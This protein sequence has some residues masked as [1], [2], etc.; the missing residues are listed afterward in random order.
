MKKIMQLT[1]FLITFLLFGLTLVAPTG[2]LMAI[3]EDT[4]TD[5]PTFETLPQKPL[6]A[7]NETQVGREPVVEPE[8]PVVATSTQ[9]QAAPNP[10]PT[11]TRRAALAQ[12]NTT[13]TPEPASPQPAGT[14]LGVSTTEETANQTSNTEIQTASQATP[15]AGL[16]KI[17]S[18]ALVCTGLVTAILL[19]MRFRTNI[20]R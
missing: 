1:L 17:L 2:S 14:A 12:P 8:P 16:E 9:T 3:D 19:Y 7:N 10:A 13:T 11:P 6:P 4:P 20:G 18:I 5:L 15:G